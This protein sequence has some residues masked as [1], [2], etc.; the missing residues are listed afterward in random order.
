[1][2]FK[3]KD[4]NSKNWRGGGLFHVWSSF[5]ALYFSPYEITPLL[6][7]SKRSSSNVLIIAWEANS[8]KNTLFQYFM[9]IVWPYTAP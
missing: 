2:T 9:N 8:T 3:T 1:M 7:F 5:K 6:L 4:D